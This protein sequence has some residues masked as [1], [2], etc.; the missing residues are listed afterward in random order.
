VGKGSPSLDVFKASLYRLP[1]ID[2]IHQIVPGGI[3]GQLVHE[4]V[5][6]VFEI[7]GGFHRGLRGE[8]VAEIWLRLG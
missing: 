3:R 8:R 6:F 5:G 7:L 1:D 4:S 2:F